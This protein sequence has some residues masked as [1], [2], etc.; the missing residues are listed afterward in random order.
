M[1]I[2]ARYT[3]DELTS[4]KLDSLIASRTSFQI[5]SIQPMSSVAE[6]VENHME[7]AGLSCQ[8]YTE[9]RSAAM[10]GSLF[11][12]VKALADVASAG[13]RGSQSRDGGP[14]L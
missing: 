10:A 11:G 13:H 14:R 7:K 1:S 6:K 12:G 4:E 8:V 2:E 3:P 9:H 5:I